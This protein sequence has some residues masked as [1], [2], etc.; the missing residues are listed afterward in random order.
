MKNTSLSQL[1]TAKLTIS[2]YNLDRCQL[3]FTVGKLVMRDGQQYWEIE[4]GTTAFSE[5]MVEGAE[6]EVEGEIDSQ[7]PTTNTN[8]T[9]PICRVYKYA[10]K[11]G[12]ANGDEDMLIFLTNKL[13]PRKYGG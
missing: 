8:S 11:S 5:E 3:A 6:K 9:A 1:S 12:F 4:P 13:E 10:P 7:S 2:E